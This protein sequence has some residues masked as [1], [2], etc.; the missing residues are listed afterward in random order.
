ME[1]KTA[2]GINITRQGMIDTV[3]INGVACLWTLNC[4]AL[5]INFTFSDE[6]LREAFAEYLRW[7]RLNPPAL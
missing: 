3:W 2:G 4:G 7:R 5:G 1:D 6:A